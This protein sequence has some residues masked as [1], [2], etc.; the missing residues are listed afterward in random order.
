VAHS[1]GLLFAARALQGLAV[2]IATGAL[3]AALIDLQ[4]AGSGLAP[5]ITAAVPALGLGA[6]A[7]GTSALAQYGPAPTRLVWWLL[8]GASVAA[9][10]GILVMPESGT[11]RV[12]VLASLRPRV[13]VPRQARGAFA[14]AVPCLFAMWALGGLYLSL[15]PALAAQVSGS[16]DLLW[17]GLSVFLLTGV[18]AGATAAFRGL[19]P[20]T[21]VLVGSLLLLVGLAVTFAAIT[22][23]VA[24]AFLIGTSVAGVG[25][26]LA[27]L[28]VNRSLIPLAAHGQRA[29]LIAAIF[30]INYLGLGIP[31]VIAGMAAAHFGLHRTALAYCVAA[32]VLIAAAAGSLMLRRHRP[33]TGQDD[34]GLH[35]TDPSPVPGR[36]IGECGRARLSGLTSLM[37]GLGPVQFLDHPVDHD[38][39]QASGSAEEEPDPCFLSHDIPFRCRVD[40]HKPAI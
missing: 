34:D 1:V 18:A 38:R 23:A 29:G 16:R 14:V 36:G 4:P 10:A 21:A 27:L 9:A 13:G 11:R 40:G 3:G 15:G 8:L 25:F 24:A 22:A 35:H 6:G 26:G 30:I 2:G 20:R 19:T 28:G 39:Q 7:L 5:L 32:A 31:V 12:G 33:A 37:A 17:G